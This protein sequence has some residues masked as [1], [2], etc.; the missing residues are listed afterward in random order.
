MWVEVGTSVVLFHSTE[1]EVLQDASIY[2]NIPN[3]C[4]YRIVATV[5]PVCNTGDFT[6]QVIDTT[7]SQSLETV[8]RKNFDNSIISEIA[9][10]S[11]IAGANYVLNVSLIGGSS[12]EKSVEVE[13]RF[14]SAG[15]V[16]MYP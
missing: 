4:S 2:P 12:T 3:L 15:K 8:N 9:G 11:L 13:L 16:Y 7:G 10:P 5:N 1:V 6:V 14:G